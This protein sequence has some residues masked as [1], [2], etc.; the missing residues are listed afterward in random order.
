MTID[1]LIV[2]SGGNGQTYF[3]IFLLKFG[4]KI[5]SY[6]DADNLKHISHSSKSPK[7]IKRCIFLYNDPLYSILSL[8]RRKWF[9]M[10]I[11]KLGNPYKL[12]QNQVNTLE[13][14]FKL[15]ETRNY[16]LFGIEY[17][18]NNWYNN[19]QN[20]QFPV[21]FID[22]NEILLHKEKINDFLGKKLD[23]TKFEMKDRNSYKQV[24]NIPP[25]V[26]KIYND[27]YKDIINKADR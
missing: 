25:L 13:K 17:Q 5:N 7:N 23:W 6:R 9:F 22:F 21:L 19:V 15:V 1:T 10:Q 3:M 18:F 4:I 16:D 20:I 14:Y 26:K 12:Q 11:K 2:G 8:Y 27:L 24:V